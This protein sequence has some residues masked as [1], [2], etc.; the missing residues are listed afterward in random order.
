MYRS[1]YARHFWSRAEL[2]ELRGGWQSSDE[3][4]ARRRDFMTALKIS[5]D[6]N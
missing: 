2:E 4:W 6:I 5:E 1:K 3:P